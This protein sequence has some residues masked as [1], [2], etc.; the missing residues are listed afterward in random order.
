[1]S[2][3]KE[4]TTAAAFIKFLNADPEHLAMRKKQDDAI[5]SLRDDRRRA[6]RP[7]VRELNESGFDVTTAWELLDR[8]EPY[9]NAL[10]I[11]LKHLQCDYPD[12]VLEGM[13]R[14]MGVPESGVFWDELVK[15]YRKIS[16]Q[17][18]RDGLASALSEIAGPEH[19]EELIEIVSDSQFGESRLLLLSALERS[20]DARARAALESLR[21]DPDL[22]L[23]IQAMFKRFESNRQRRVKR[24]PDPRT[25]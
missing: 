19:L 17:A 25:K 6:E 8:R 2:E 14:A 21:E 15:L 9:P 20:K 22:R 10:P 16:G 12:L 18:A 24:K 13:A 5:T 23:E 3:K 4:P 11:L 1:M 7:L